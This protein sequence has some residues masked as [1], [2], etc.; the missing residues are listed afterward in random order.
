[1]FSFLRTNREFLIYKFEPFLIKIQKL[2]IKQSKDI[3]TLAIAKG[4]PVKASSMREHVCSINAV[5]ALIFFQ[6]YGSLSSWY[7]NVL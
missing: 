5:V 1:M 6:G 2:S 7:R 4:I 3:F